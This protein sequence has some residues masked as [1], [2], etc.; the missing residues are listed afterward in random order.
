MAVIKPYQNLFYDNISAPILGVHF[1]FKLIA[2]VS[3]I[4]NVMTNDVYKLIVS[5]LVGLLQRKYSVVSCLFA[6]ASSHLCMPK[7][8]LT[9]RDLYF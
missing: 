3:I 6:V 7:K 4:F 9:S 2:A 5:L 1:V 8:L